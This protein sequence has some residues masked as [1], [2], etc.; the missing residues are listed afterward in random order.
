MLYTDGVT[1]AFKADGETFDAERLS[2]VVRAH[3]TAS[4]QELLKA[5]ES[6]VAVFTGGVPQSDDITLLVAR[7]QPD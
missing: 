6:K 5:I 7:C 3:R 1:E 2:Q 4:A